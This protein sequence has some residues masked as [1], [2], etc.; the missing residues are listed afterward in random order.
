[1][2]NYVVTAHKP[3]AVPAAATA[4]FTGPNDLNLILR[5]ILALVLTDNA[6]QIYAR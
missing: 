2:F 6:Q 1:M 3:T 5:C 4:N